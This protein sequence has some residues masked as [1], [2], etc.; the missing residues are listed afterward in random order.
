MHACILTNI[1][2]LAQTYMNAQINTF[3]H[4]CTCIHNYRQERKDNVIATYVG[5]VV[6][7]LFGIL[8]LPL[9]IVFPVLIA[10]FSF[11]YISAEQ[12]ANETLEDFV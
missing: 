7:G 3:I 2:T 5:H 12:R 11:P 6:R 1:Y 9:Y 10:A 4:I 8:P